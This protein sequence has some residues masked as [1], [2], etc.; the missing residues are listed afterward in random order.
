MAAPDTTSAEWIAE[1]PSACLSS[2][3]GCRQAPLT[4]FGTVHFSK[5]S[6]NNS[7]GHTG[8]ISDPAWSPTALTLQSDVGGSAFGRY[9]SVMTPDLATPTGLSGGG[10]SFAVKW[11]TEASSGG[12]YGYRGSG[13][14]P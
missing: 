2:G 9:R 10:A 11:S 12:G 8:P 4:N 3:S 14:G 5:S 1:A 6:L 13:Y 7:S